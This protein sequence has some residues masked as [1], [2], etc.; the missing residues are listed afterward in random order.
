MLS[1]RDRN[2]SP[3]TVSIEAHMKSVTIA[4]VED[5]EVLALN[6]LTFLAGDPSRI[7]RFLGLTGLAPS[8]LMAGVENRDVQVA[9][10][11]HLMQNE[12]DLLVFTSHRQVSGDAVGEALHWLAPDE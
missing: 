12:S 5:A 8:D 4:S 7:E 6:A 2:T 9:V 11:R 10:L 3:E 1:Y